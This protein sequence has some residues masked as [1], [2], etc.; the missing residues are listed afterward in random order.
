MSVND[1]PVGR[2]VDEVF[3]LVQGYQ[4]F[5]EHGEVCPA[6]WKPGSATIKPDPSGKMDYFEKSA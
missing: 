4:F 1:P 3:R 2:S 6:K 5:E